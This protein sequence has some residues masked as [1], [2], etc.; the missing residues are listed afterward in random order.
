MDA[1]RAAA[2]GASE[3]RAITVTV[4]GIS[5]MGKSALVRRFL[6][7]VKR[8]HNAIVLRGRCY[9]RESVPYKAVDALMDAVSRLL[10]AERA[11]TVSA[12]LPPNIH[13]LARLFPVLNDVP[14]VALATRDKEEVPDLQELRKR[15]FEALR[16]LFARIAK[17]HPLVLAIDD[18]QW[19]D[20]DSA[21]LLTAL[22][23]P[24]DPPPLLLVCSFRSD[25]AA[26]S[27]FLRE[28]VTEGSSFRNASGGGALDIRDVCVGPL[29]REQATALASELLRGAR[30]QLD[31]SLIDDMAAQIARE[32]EG[33][34]FF[35][36]ELARAIDHD[37]E[38]GRSEPP[39]SLVSEPLSPEGPP[40]RRTALPRLDQVVRARV[41]RLGEE[42]RALL[43]VVA[44]AG[45]PIEQSVALK[46]A[47]QTSEAVPTL[48]LLRS[49][50]LVR[51]RGVRLSDLVEPYH[52]RIREAVLAGLDRDRRRERHL[53]LAQELEGSGR[54]D[55]EMLAEHFVGAG[56]RP[57]AQKYATLAA[58]HAAS[59][60]AFERAATLYRTALDHTDAADPS[61]WRIS[62]DLGEALANAGR[63]AEASKVYGDAVRTA[64]ARHVLE[65]E[66]LAAEHACRSGHVDEGVAIFRRVTGAV[67]MRMA[68][69]PTEALAS[70]LARRALVR[71][72]GLRT[73]ERK[74]DAIAPEILDKLD[75]C[76]SVSVG[77]GMVDPI[78]GA[79]FQARLLLLA[80]EAGEPLRLSRAL[81]IEACYSSTGGEDTRPR[82]AMLIEAAN[83]L[84]T[85]V[86]SP[87]ASSMVESA[88]AFDDIFVGR[89][90]R[91]LAHAEEAERLMREN[92]TS[93]AHEIATAQIFGLWALFNL[94]D[95]PELMRRYPDQIRNAEERGDLFAAGSK[96]TLVGHL[97]HLCQ[98]D[99]EGA[100][101]TVRLGMLGW[102]QRGFHVQHWYELSSGVNTDMY[103]GDGEG[104]F[105]RLES[106]WREVERSLLMRIVSIRNDILFLRGRAALAAALTSRNKKKLLGIAEADAKKIASASL[107]NAEGWSRCLMSSVHFQRGDRERAIT[108][109][110]RAAEAFLRSDMS[111]W[112]RIAQRREGQMLGGLAG[113][114]MIEAA[115]A[116]IRERGV[117]RPDRFADMLAPGISET[118]PSG[119]PR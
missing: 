107:A 65:L 89:W 2:R 41:G 78:Q 9:E 18:L 84:A 39:P 99:V 59:T 90:K 5:G 62:R 102:S 27:P 106:K 91:G 114:Q 92:C 21:A 66:R 76:Y 94:G 47:G 48:G 35:V 75:V 34:P 104:A 58:K 33:S 4:H 103:A 82:T 13:A 117:L 113:A 108:E 110:R 1:L 10:L 52:D 81:A 87:L 85:R 28:L 93:V 57:R 6:D 15:G 116:W 53:A 49:E 119:P 69:S 96:R 97:F 3:G 109:E 32:A 37:E 23:R 112:A 98:D 31:E 74:E 56:D 111:L 72:R 40:G 68:T 73:V 100:R 24:P 83:A 42:A 36:A 67:G 60:L 70:L 19:G 7:E 14:A 54:A 64:P 88:R 55:P 11:E 71:L 80:L 25:E 61:H 8:D 30:S 29:S 118:D 22:L 63:S 51:T 44:V 12:L 43:E 50:H 38:T 46:A 101:E 16:E 45:R 86:G 115:D 79:D 20:A 77:L 26:S 95:L 17:G 105:K